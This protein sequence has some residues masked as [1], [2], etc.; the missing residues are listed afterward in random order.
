MK[1]AWQ[2]FWFTRSHRERAVLLA[3]CVILAFVLVYVFV[4]RPLIQSSERLRQA[5]PY[6]QRELAVIRELANEIPTLRKITPPT[7]PSNT[8]TA[9]EASAVRYQIR[10]AVSQLERLEDNRVKLRF[11][12]VR[13][14]N[15]IAWL[16]ALQREDRLRI[17]ELQLAALTQ[18]G[19]A[20]AEVSLTP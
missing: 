1:Q 2:A 17:A 12:N 7:R 18:A 4:W 10:E 15:L 13:V 6:Q 8:V 20:R 11:N 19:M 3:A 5:L 14:S 9:I 16:E